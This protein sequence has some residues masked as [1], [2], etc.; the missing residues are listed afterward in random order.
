VYLYSP[1]PRRAGLRVFA[2]WAVVD[3]DRGVWAQHTLLLFQALYGI[4]DLNWRDFSLLILFS[5]PLELSVSLH[6]IYTSCLSPLVSAALSFGHLSSFRM[7]HTSFRTQGGV[8]AERSLGSV[9]VCDTA[10]N[11]SLDGLW[12]E[13]QSL[14]VFVL[15]PA[16]G[17][18][19]IHARILLAFMLARCRRTATFSD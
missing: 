16:V 19:T 14:L 17:T 10:R 4:S 7:L 8:L 18:P 1:P 11:G 9:Y 2:Q 13:H 5:L 15:P 6:C 12:R 3:G